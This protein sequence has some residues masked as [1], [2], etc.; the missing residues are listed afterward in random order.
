VLCDMVQEVNTTS[1]RIK[2]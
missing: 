2:R 1:P